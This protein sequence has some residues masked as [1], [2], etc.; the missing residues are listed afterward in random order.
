MKQEF[1]KSL[2]LSDDVIAQIQAENGK[3]VQ[4]EKD[5][6][7]KVQDDLTALNAKIGEY[8]D[9][10]KAF[11]KQ[12][13]A[14]LAAKI[15]E[16]QKVIDDRKAADAKAIHDKNMSDRLDKVTGEKKYLNE[17]TRNGIL[18]EFMS[19]VEDKANAGKSDTDLFAQIIKDRDGIFDSQNKAVEIPGV[20]SIDS[21]AFNENKARQVMGLPP[22]K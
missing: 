1:L 8:E 21:K 15:E 7:K 19:A 18:S 20:N 10:I 13:A 6:A 11:E 22:L 3:D 17:Y 4:A 5:K 12:D 16:L 9:K 2:N 14:G